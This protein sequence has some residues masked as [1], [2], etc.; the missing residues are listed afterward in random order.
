[1]RVSSHPLYLMEYLSLFYKEAA[2]R[3]K[4]NRRVKEG[5]RQRGKVKKGMVPKGNIERAKNMWDKGAM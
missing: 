4:V 3:K 1:M 2:Q 5:V